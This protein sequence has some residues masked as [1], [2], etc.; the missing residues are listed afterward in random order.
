M[1]NSLRPTIECVVYVKLSERQQTICPVIPSLSEE[2]PTRSTPP[3]AGEFSRLRGCHP[4]VT[5]QAS[6]WLSHWTARSCVRCLAAL[7]SA[8]QLRDALT[9]DA[10][11]VGDDSADDIPG[12]LG[13]RDQADRDTSTDIDDIRIV[14]L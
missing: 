2:S 8:Q 3:S 7:Y 5:W 14:A 6:G 11:G 12:W 13:C 9:Q 4:G 10:F 1:T